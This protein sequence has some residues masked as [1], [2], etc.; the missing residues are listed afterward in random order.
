M[1]VDL[2]LSGESLRSRKLYLP[3]DRS[4]P[5]VSKI[6]K[7]EVWW[8]WS[9][10]QSL[11]C[12]LVW[13]Q[14]YHLKEPELNEHQLGRAPER[15]PTIQIFGAGDASPLSYDTT[16]SLDLLNPWILWPLL[17]SSLEWTQVVPT[18]FAVP[19]AAQDPVVFP[20]L[21][22]VRSVPGVHR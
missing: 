18:C 12:Q 16:W 19:T 7:D 9:L 1:W 4:G 10:V 14:G 2:T 17:L 13:N 22:V 15:Q 8:L 11:S 6:Q 5:R 3:R 20:R 21:L